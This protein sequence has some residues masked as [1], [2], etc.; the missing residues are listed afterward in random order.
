MKHGA[1]P[2]IS[3]NL[4]VQHIPTPALSPHHW[5]INTDCEF[6]SLHKTGSILLSLMTVSSD[7]SPVNMV[8]VNKRYTE[9]TEEHEEVK[10]FISKS[11][12]WSE[13]TN[14]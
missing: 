8:L 11:D 7:Q 1:D 6:T 13:R 12:E 9:K 5:K 2:E 10:D 3:Y 14:V 4:D